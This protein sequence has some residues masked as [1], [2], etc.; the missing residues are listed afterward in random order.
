M[1]A[2]S[3]HSITSKSPC[4]RKGVLHR[5]LANGPLVGHAFQPS[6]FCVNSILWGASSRYTRARARPHRC[7][8]YRLI[9]NWT[10]AL[11]QTLPDRCTIQPDHCTTQSHIAASRDHVSAPD[12]GQNTRI[13]TSLHQIETDH[14]TKPG[15][16][17]KQTNHNTPHDQISSPDPDHCYCSAR[18]VEGTTEPCH[19]RGALS[20]PR[21]AR[22]SAHRWNCDFNCAQQH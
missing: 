12:P 2:T 15:R 21:E 19:L 10:P 11:Y 1:H 17:T 18:L 4:L 13:S 9:G 8:V 20:R 22:C 5:A 3:N 7:P 14:Y 6:L 16:C